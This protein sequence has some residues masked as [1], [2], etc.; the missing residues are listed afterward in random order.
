VT[1]AVAAGVGTWLLLTS[2]PA[3]AVVPTDGGLVAVYSGRF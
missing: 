1:G 2:P 3:V